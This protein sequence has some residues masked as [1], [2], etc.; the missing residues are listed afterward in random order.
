MATASK[1]RRRTVP[2]PASAGA[3]GRRPLPWPVSTA[4]AVLLIGLLT[5]PMLVSHADTGQSWYVH[6]WYLAHQAG[7]IRDNG[8]PSLFVHDGPAVFNPHYAFYG[9]SLYAAAGALALAIGSV[10]AAYVISWVLGFAAAYGGWLW[11]GRS[12]GVRGWWAHIP[13][14][15]FITSPYYLALP[16]SEGDWPEFMAVSTIPLLMASILDVLVAERLRPL[17]AL[18]LAAGT[19]LFFGSHNITMLW[20]TTVL[21]IAATAVALAVPRA[22]RRVTRRGVLRLAAVMAPAVCVDA[23]FLAPDLAYHAHTLIAGDS[24]A[25]R[26]L[27]TW[28]APFVAPRHLLSLDRSTV[29]PT[30]LH[31]SLQLPVPGLAWIVAGLAVLRPGR[32]SP[33]LRANI[34]LLVL[35]AALVV[36]MT[37]VGMLLALPGPYG[38]LQFGYRLESYIL[39]AV[40]GAVLG[41]LVLAA[42][43]GPRRARWSWL[44]VPIL[45]VS[46]IQ[47]AAQVDVH[48][49][50][51]SD[52][53]AFKD[54]AAR[55]H[56][57]QV[58]PGITDFVSRDLPPIERIQGLRHVRFAASAQDGDRAAITVDARPGQ[59][60][61]T[62]AMTMPELVDLGGARFAGRSNGYAVVEV[63]PGA[64]P[65]AARITLRAARPLPVAIGQAL[66]LFGVAALA[67]HGVAMSLGWRRRRRTAD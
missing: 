33:W 63:P 16:Y 60:F 20:G 34:V 54:V 10:K 61:I 66:S 67:A 18:A 55:Y 37:N 36:L 53:M 51:V 32:R 5:R 29:E 26:F 15:L 59:R 38:L 9:G 12:A 19:V 25:W 47:A 56:T 48:R 3:S 27:L 17:P 45:A 39:L 41:V 31:F 43:A 28:S 2:A 11:L 52:P 35:I 13:G 50:H 40:S 58:A 24:A 42:A 8:V 4:G 46:V 57:P 44:V 49:P 14:A 21:A 1:P 64:T 22:R 62:N 6:L 7:S 23:W 65:G 30:I